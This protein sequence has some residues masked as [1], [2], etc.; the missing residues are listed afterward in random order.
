YYGT[1]RKAKVSQAS[2]NRSLGIGSFNRAYASETLTLP[3][4]PLDEQPLSIFEN[5]P[6]ISQHHPSLPIVAYS[7]S[8]EPN[9][10]RRRHFL[11]L[12]FVVFSD[13]SS[14]FFSFLSF[15]FLFMY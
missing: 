13:S 9:A 6:T 10:R 4:R 15:A 8:L 5:A 2:S 7:L 12:G 1:T 3:T 11:R 14:S